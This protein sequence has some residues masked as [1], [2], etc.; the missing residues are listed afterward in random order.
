MTWVQNAR[1][2]GAHA[3]WFENLYALYTLGLMRDVVDAM[4]APGD[5]PTYVLKL[6]KNVP[7]VEY[8]KAADLNAPVDRNRITALFVRGDDAE[9]DRDGPRV[10]IA[11]YPYLRELGAPRYYPGREY[12]PR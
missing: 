11:G 7:E 8:I 9:R 1:A 6:P 12:G 4:A 10:M 5:T 2:S 3:A